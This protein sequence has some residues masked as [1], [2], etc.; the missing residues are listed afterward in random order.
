[1]VPPCTHAQSATGAWCVVML[2][3][4]FLSS[5]ISLS[6][7]FVTY[8]WQRHLDSWLWVLHSKCMIQICVVLQRL[9][10]VGFGQQV[11]LLLH[12]PLLAQHACM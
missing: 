9:H 11:G 1:M 2:Y 7:T 10:L 8:L 4:F 5:T 3:R 12:E 6:S